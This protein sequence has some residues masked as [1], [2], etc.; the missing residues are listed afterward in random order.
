MAACTRVDSGGPIESAIPVT[1][2]KRSLLAPAPTRRLVAAARATRHACVH[3]TSCAR[4]TATPRLPNPQAGGSTPSGRATPDHQSGYQLLDN[5]RGIVPGPPPSSTIWRSGDIGS[6]CA[7]CAPPITDASRLTGR[8]PGSYPGRD[9][10]RGPGRVPSRRSSARKSAGPSHR[11]SR[12]RVPSVAPRRRGRMDQ[13]TGLRNR[14]VQ[15]RILPSTPSR[16]SSA[17]RA[18]PSEGGDRT[19]ESCRRDHATTMEATRPDEEPVSNTGR[20]CT[21]GRSSRPASATHASRDGPTVTTPGPQL[22]DRGSTPRRGAQLQPQRSHKSMPG[23]R[24]AR[25]PA[26]TRKAGVRVSPWQPPPGGR[27]S[28]H[29]AANRVT[30]VRVPPGRPSHHRTTATRVVVVQRRGSRCATPVMRVRIPPATPLL[31]NCPTV[32]RLHHHCAGEVLKARTLAS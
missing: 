15:V 4:V 21:L 28:R 13:G 22:G 3:L 29:T 31:R 9:W 16:R 24:A 6:V 23:S 20:G 12:V 17:E 5:C 14:R 18:P 2:G 26:V 1:A 27:G 25:H 11:R 10:V 8:A 19:F 7:W 32:P 30:G